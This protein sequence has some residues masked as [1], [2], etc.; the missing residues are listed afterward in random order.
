MRPTVQLIVKAKELRYDGKTYRHGEPIDVLEKDVRALK[1]IGK[2]V[3]PDQA[4]PLRVAELKATARA[5]RAPRGRGR[6]LDRR[7][8]QAED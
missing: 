8:M 4:S 2:V 6:L 1:L 7:D 3:D 5:V